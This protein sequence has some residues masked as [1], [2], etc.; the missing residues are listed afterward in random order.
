VRDRKLVR[1]LAPDRARLRP[2]AR[3]AAG[4]QAE[5]GG[6]QGTA[7]QLVRSRREAGA[8]LERTSKG[9]KLAPREVEPDRLNSMLVASPPANVLRVTPSPARHFRD[10]AS[11][12]AKR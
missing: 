6:H 1:W 9:N 10:S 5:A 12:G 2:S 8:R 4:Q 7:V 11:Q 3:L